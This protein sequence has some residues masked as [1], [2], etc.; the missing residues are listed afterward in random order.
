L[1]WMVVIL[2]YRR[3]RNF[4]RVF[5]FLCLALFFFYGGSLL[6]LN[7]QIYYQLPPPMLAV[8][9]QTVIVIGLW[10]L[11]AL[12]T[13]F[14]VEYGEARG[15]LQSRAGK[16]S[17]VA[18][19]YLPLPYLLIREHLS[20]PNA[21]RFDFLTPVNSFGPGFK[22]WLFL[23]LVVCCLWQGRFFRF[24]TDKHEKDFHEMALL[25]LACAAFLVL[26]I[27]MHMRN[28]MAGQAELGTL[29][30]LLPILP[31]G[32]LVYS[33]QK[34]NFL[35]IGRQRN[36]V[37][38]VSI[39]FVAL[40]YLSAIRRV[41]EWLEP[42][43]PPEATAA[44]LVFVLVALFE[45]IQRVVS[46]ILRTTALNEFDR[47]HRIMGAINETARLGNFE[48]LRRFAEKWV[49]EQLELA[50]VTLTMRNVTG[51]D[52]RVQPGQRGSENEFE[53]CHAGRSIGNL[54]VR[55]HGAMLS[56]ET[57]AALEYL[58][59]QL[60]GALELC[61]LIEEKVRLERELAERERMAAL[62]QMAA[63]ISHNLKNP[64]GSIKTILQV[65]LENPELPKT[66]RGE[67]QLILEEIGRLSSKLNQLLQFSRPTITGEKD[68]STSD[69]AVVAR[70][71]TEVL[72]HE[73]DRKGVAL[74]FGESA[75][76]ACVQASNEAVSD[77]LSNLV[78]NA[79]EAAP[80]GG[81]VRVSVSRNEDGCL[82]AV[83]DDGP[84]IPQELSEKILQ[85]FFTTKTH[86]TGLG[87]AIVARRASEVGGSVEFVSPA[88]NGRG[89]RFVVT[90]PLGDKKR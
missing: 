89:T 28:G 64:L 42:V 22:I 47:S 3:Q 66:I 31:L 69:A 37:Y 90:L 26:D 2:G 71:V 54:L 15:L 46:R 76:P 50:E 32:A 86:G 68:S 25:L 1:F 23:A 52:G 13:H 57:R 30:A 77:I 88:R 14:H 67:T 48:K 33:V 36:L 40:L 35:Q 82:L 45:P 80:R 85:P 83:E 11:P 58:C 63:S 75:M 59:E 56:G 5:F 65:Q 43:L 87:L 38:A 79:L 53:I 19:A 17:W 60:P 78:M 27:H 70:E 49:R 9:S 72:R 55:P 6:A 7:A 20:T 16:W 74:L 62:G 8:F 61:R 4:E 41:G 84:G 39:T 18:V 10:V 73:A 51:L 81:S 21:Q 12:L 24:A 29:L 34:H 44:I